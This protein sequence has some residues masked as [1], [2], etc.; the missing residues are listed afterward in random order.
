MSKGRDVA[1]QFDTTHAEE[2]K[3][4]SSSN[5]LGIL[6]EDHAHAPLALPW[7]LS[8]VDVESCLNKIT[9]VEY[10]EVGT[11]LVLERY[12]CACWLT[13]DVSSLALVRDALVRSQSHGVEL[14]LLAR[15]MHVAV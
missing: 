13:W 3:R 4:T 11:R 8:L 15:R 10:K 6:A 12:T 1:Y 5:G 2:A 14:W 7:K 9:P